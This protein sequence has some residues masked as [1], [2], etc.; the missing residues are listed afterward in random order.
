MKQILLAF[1]TCTAFAAE[2][3]AHP[4]AGTRTVDFVKEVAPI[5]EAKCVKCHGAEKQ[6]SGYRLDIKKDA[7]TG[8]DD[9]AP[10]I[11]PGKSAESPLIRFVAGIDPDV[12]MPPK[13]DA[14]TA[15]EVGLLRAWIDQGAVWP[16][17]AS[18]AKRDPLDWWSLKPM[19]KTAVPEAKSSVPS[20]RSSA[21]DGATADKKLSTNPID[22]FI[23]EKLAGKNL[24]P[25]PEAD[26]RT[27]CRRLYFDL[28]GLP[29]TPE[30]SDAFV[31][32]CRDGSSF[33]IRH[34]ALEK[35]V[36]GLLG[37]G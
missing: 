12:K 13:G 5:F 28:I 31:A 11:L 32:G 16:E 8:G 3:G 18:V 9:H 34:S 14:L 6:K 21:N 25:S 30:E 20:P 29:P 36:D 37:L 33:V 27:L 22:A 24:T 4:P 15:E 35:L 7:L 17:D 26:P 23:R 1:A 10:N 2:P 19:V